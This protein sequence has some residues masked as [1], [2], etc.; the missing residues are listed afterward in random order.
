MGSSPAQV[1]TRLVEHAALDQ[2]RP[3]RVS[4]SVGGIPAAPPPRSRS[5]PRR[6]RPSGRNS[7]LRPVSWATARRLTSVGQ[8]E[9]GRGLLAL[10]DRTQASHPAAALLAHALQQQLPAFP[11]RLPTKLGVE[12]HRNRRRK[13]RAS[14]ST[15]LPISERSRRERTRRGHRSCLPARQSPQ[16]S[17]EPGQWQRPRGLPLSPSRR[18][19]EPASG[20]RSPDS[21]RYGRS[22]ESTSRNFLRIR[23]MKDRT[24]ER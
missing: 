12:D 9:Q 1:L 22:S 18:L 2:P 8:R 20:S 24:L 10:Q 21:C 3:A 16:Y 5:P 23:L 14:R 6:S 4:S 11:D 19:P 15:S 17:L 13:P 7:T